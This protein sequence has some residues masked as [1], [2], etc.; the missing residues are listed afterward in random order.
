MNIQSETIRK[1]RYGHL[2]EPHIP[3][4]N[5][6]KVADIATGTGIW[7]LEAATELEQAGNTDV[8][9][10][11]FDISNAQFPKDA[12]PNMQFEVA[13]IHQGFA[14]KWHGTFD[15]VHLRLLLVVLTVD[16]IEPAVQNVVK[17]L[18]K[19]P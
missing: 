8:H 18:R 3:K 7:L 9:F 17:L 14:E 1:L 6:R 11:G 5:I 2:L 16:Q 13:D 4:G 19:S 10:V 15:V 12:K